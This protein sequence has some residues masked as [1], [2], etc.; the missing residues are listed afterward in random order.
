[1]DAIECVFLKYSDI[2][3]EFGWCLIKRNQNNLAFF[4]RIT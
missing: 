4:T 2:C 3:T 1:M